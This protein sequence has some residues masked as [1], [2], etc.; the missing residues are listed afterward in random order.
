MAHHALGNLD[1]AEVARQE[2]QEAY[3]NLAAAQQAWI[4]AYWGEFE[5]AIDWL[6]IAVD[7]HDSGIIDLKTDPAFVRLRGHPRYEALLRKMNVTASS[8]ND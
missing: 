1:E 4:F 7:I 6:E 3:G 2:L 8:A 5:T